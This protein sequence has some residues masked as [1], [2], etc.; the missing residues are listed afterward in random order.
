MIEE[1][2]GDLM[3]KIKIVNH[4]LGTRCLTDREVKWYCV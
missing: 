4:R 1:G 3:Q 2:V